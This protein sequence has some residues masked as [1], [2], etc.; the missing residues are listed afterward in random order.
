M[1]AL[2]VALLLLALIGACGWP[3]WLMLPSAFVLLIVIAA[4]GGARGAENVTR[5]EPRFGRSSAKVIDLAEA[6]RRRQ[7]S[8]PQPSET[9]PLA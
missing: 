2:G 8:T 7:T 1:C 5:R 4:R 9:A 3:W 6:R